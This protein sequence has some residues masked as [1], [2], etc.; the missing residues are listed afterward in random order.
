LT[1]KGHD[2]LPYLRRK[3]RERFLRELQADGLSLSAAVEIIDRQ[4]ARL[5]SEELNHMLADLAARSIER[6][7]GDAQA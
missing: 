3:G 1:A 7:L 6:V 4:E 5:S 2:A